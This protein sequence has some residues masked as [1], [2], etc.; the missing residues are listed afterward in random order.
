MRGRVEKYL[1]DAVDRYGTIHLSLIDPQNIKPDAAG[2]LARNL[3]E[4]GSSAI[5]I[6]G[7]TVVSQLDLDEVVKEIKRNT[8]IPAILFPNGIAGISKHADAIFF[9]T[10]MNSSNPYFITGVQALGAP[11][12]KRYGLEALPMGYIVVGSSPG[13]VGFVGQASPIPPDKPELAAMYALAAEYLGMRF[14]YLEAGSGSER[15]ASLD[16]IRYVRDTVGARLIVGGGI[17]TPEQASEIA[18]AGADAIVTGNIIEESSIEN[19][20]R[21]IAGL[22]RRHD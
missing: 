9:S 7:S 18:K 8:D 4:I 13:T 20:G 19:A 15:P 3:S 17:R 21:L 16:M 11:L 10:L 5:M 1:N 12:V 14:I 22:R 6:G 2:V